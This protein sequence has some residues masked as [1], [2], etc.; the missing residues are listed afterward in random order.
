LYLNNEQ[1]LLALET[2]QVTIKRV[3]NSQGQSDYYLNESRCRLKDI[4][5]I[6]MD[7]GLGKNS[8][9]I[10]GQGQ[11][12]SIINSKPEVLRQL[13]EESAGISKHKARKAETEKRLEENNSDLQRIADLISE[14][15]KQLP[16]L[17]EGAEK[18]REYKKLYS[19]LKKLEVNL[20]H[21]KWEQKKDELTE[22][23]SDYKDLQKQLEK[24][25]KSFTQ[26]NKKLEEKKQTLE[27][28]EDALREKKDEYYTLKAKKEE[29]KNKLD[30]NREKQRALKR[31][32]EE[33]EGQLRKAKQRIT[34][35]QEEKEFLR[36]KISQVKKNK[37]Q[38]EEKLAHKE[39]E[40]TEKKNTISE[41][42]AKIEKIRDKFL[43]D[44][45]LEQLKSE[46]NKL[47]E[48]I[49][50]TKKR[51]KEITVNSKLKLQQ[52][53]KVLAEKEK[54]TKQLKAIKQKIASQKKQ[55][56]KGKQKR[57]QIAGHLDEIREKHEKIVQRF[58]DYNSR[59]D[60]LQER[61]KN[62]RGF[63]QGV[64]SILKN[65]DQFPGLI[66]VIAHILQVE[67]RLEKAVA[68]ALGSRMQNIVVKTDRTARQGI[69]FLQSHNAGQATFLPLNMIQGY[70][71]NENNLGLK[72]ID[73]Y[74]GIG[75]DLVSLS[76]EDNNLCKYLLGKIIF[77]QN[78]KVAT[79][80]AKKTN[81]KHKIVSLK[82]NIINPGGAMTGGSSKNRQ[83]QF[84]ERKR[85]I[86]D[87]QEKISAL[88]EK[89]EQTGKQL[90]QQQ[91]KRATNK[92]KI[93]EKSKKLQQLEM[94]KNSLQKDLENQKNEI[95]RYHSTLQELI[96]EYQ[97]QIKDLYQMQKKYK[98]RKKDLLVFDQDFA[99]EKEKINNIK[100]EIAKKE[101]ELASYQEEKTAIKIEIAT[102]EQ[103]LKDLQQDIEDNKNT[104]SNT[105]QK[106]ETIK[107]RINEIAKKQKDLKEQE[108]NLKTQIKEF[109]HQVQ[110][111]EKR[112]EEL[113]EKSNRKKETV[114]NL[115]KKV[116]P[117]RQKLESY[118]DNLHQM[119]LKISRIENS[120]QRRQEKLKEEYNFIPGKD[121]PAEKIEIDNYAR[122][123]RKI[124]KLKKEINKLL[125]VNEAAIEEYEELK[126]RVEYLTDQREDLLEARNSLKKVI[127]EI[128]KNMGQLFYETYIQVKEEFEDI[129]QELFAGGQAELKL[130]EPDD[131]LHTGVDIAAQ[132]PGKQLKELSLLSGGERALTAIALVFAFLQV[133]PS[134][135]YILDEI[136][137]PLDDAN[138]AKFT[139]FIER[140]SEIAQFIIITHRKYMMSRVDTL[141][142][143][144]MEESGIS[145]VL[146]LKLNEEGVK[147]A[148]N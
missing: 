74:I 16:S 77:V 20:L 63:Y 35:I 55:I 18:A 56:E 76:I 91:E 128:E 17:K 138:L 46:K 130:T 90:A 12:T 125:P 64:K 7:T 79:R 84:L 2:D 37:Q 78:M 75:S 34:K 114:N 148:R 109:K 105:Q 123:E 26:L 89:K 48:N 24:H 29:T 121:S 127:D 14:L 50:F 57:L 95:S 59:L 100:A 5:N 141:Y 126:E 13:F 124:K 19:R 73:G 38:Q 68:A 25:Q 86:Q 43:E 103:K 15:K 82:G 107:T 145:R 52:T 133:N 87:L 137:A 96:G 120:Q 23:Y 66:D 70:Q 30:I 134:P 3:V 44:E 129:F 36:E 144:T 28:T 8:Y 99:R 135:L 65:E 27:K 53:K 140:Y 93:N 147:F 33:K 113:D 4:E 71:I 132:P 146:S 83:Q 142:G 39:K 45:D 122:V 32:N 42:K 31:E 54:L 119:D 22:L 112:I 11:V 51:L 102:L 116:E 40:I 10:V 117:A 67:K 62:Y 1:D 9:S 58:R 69:E 49:K 136:D 94:D 6:L 101:N 21:D 72:D 115:E 139:D 111:A 92:Q 143:V 85:E 118:K 80:I 97:S 61:E 108:A 104:I 106:K 47:E 41:L 110:K 98:Q 81:S 60:F 88:E 131:Y